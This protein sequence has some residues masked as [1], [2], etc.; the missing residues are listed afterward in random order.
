MRLPTAGGSAALISVCSR[1][2]SCD[3]PPR[4]PR[5]GR[6]SSTEVATRL[7]VRDGRMGG[8]AEAALMTGESPLD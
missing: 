3:L 6:G 7:S 8:R 4:H 1:V 2:L 5:V